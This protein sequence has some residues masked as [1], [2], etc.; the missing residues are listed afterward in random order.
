[1]EV[2]EMMQFM[3]MK[4]EIGYEAEVRMIIYKVEKEM[5][6]YLVIEEKIH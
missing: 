2:M 5:I 4:E 6:C 1:V 3:E